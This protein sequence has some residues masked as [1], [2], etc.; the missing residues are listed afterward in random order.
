[1]SRRDSCKIVAYSMVCYIT[2]VQTVSCFVASCKHGIVI[3]SKECSGARGSYRFSRV[4]TCVTSQ[5]AEQAEL[6]W[7]STQH[8]VGCR[9]TKLCYGRGTARRACPYKK[10]LAIDE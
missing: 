1:M 2:P 3:V 5:S 10:K 8:T 6:V 4:S 9:N 7:K